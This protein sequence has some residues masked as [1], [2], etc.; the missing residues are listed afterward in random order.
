LKIDFKKNID[1]DGRDGASV[2]VPERWELGITTPIF[3]RSGVAGAVLQ[4]PSSFFN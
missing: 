2:R 3:N 4:T 1:S